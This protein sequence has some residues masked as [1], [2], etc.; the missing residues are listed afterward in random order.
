[1][2]SSLDVAVKRRRSCDPIESTATAG[3]V[4]GVGSA[5]ATAPL[6]PAPPLM[7][8]PPPS[9]PPPLPAP[10]TVPWLSCPPHPP[11][12]P[13][14]EEDGGE[15]EGEQGTSGIVQRHASVCVSQQRTVWSA[16]PLHKTLP[17]RA[18]CK[19]IT[20]LV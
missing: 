17:S 6:C 1:M 5:A 14:A 7:V 15:E 8:L 20:S 12:D 19:H 9:P 4:G 11:C 16:E 18:T 3:V 10:S 2:H 13:S